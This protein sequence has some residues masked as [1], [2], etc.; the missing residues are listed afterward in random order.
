M[1]GAYHALTRNK[2]GTG[3][4]GAMCGGILRGSSN[5]RDDNDVG[6][7]VCLVKQRA[8]LRHAPSMTP[9]LGVEMLAIS[10]EPGPMET[11]TVVAQT[12]RGKT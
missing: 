9:R 6:V 5:E 2:R 11:S 3:G 7:W 8:G 1:C 10:K 12:T 4:V